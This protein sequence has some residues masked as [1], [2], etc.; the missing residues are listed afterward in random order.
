M[1]VCAVQLEGFS[2]SS[3]AAQSRILMVFPVSRNGIVF[4]ALQLAQEGKAQLLQTCAMESGGVWHRIVEIFILW[5]Q[6]DGVHEPAVSA[7]ETFSMPF[8]EC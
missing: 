5:V 4:T 1:T 7:T 3:R 8:V 6:D 2:A